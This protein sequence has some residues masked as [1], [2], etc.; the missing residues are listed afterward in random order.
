MK[1]IIVVVILTIM[2]VISMYYL[3]RGEESVQL[4]KQ[5]CPMYVINMDSS[6]ERYE[7]FVES[8]NNSQFKNYKIDR[9]S[10]I[11]GK[12][13][14]PTDW[15]SPHGLQEF[16]EV[17]NNGYRTKHHQLTRGGI[18]CFL[19]H[20]FLAQQLL[21][22]P[23][24]DYYLIFED[25]AKFDNQSYS[26]ILKAFEHAPDDWDYLMFRTIMISGNEENEYFNKLG[27][28]WLMIC[29]MMNKQGARKLVDEVQ[30]HMIDGQ[31]DAYLSRMSLQDKINIYGVKT[32]CISCSWA[33]DSSIQ[34]DIVTEGVDEFDYNGVDLNPQN[35]Y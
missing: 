29:Y 10:A 15:L 8:C 14:E 17:Q 26:N 22:D 12:T 1:T 2:I 9:F 25:D 4:E 6:K 16:E 19:S 20:Y 30:K 3:Y 13:V 33:T 23:D 31:I 18:G 32:D 34:N 27:S 21:E 35:I 11:D 28:F 5:L 7:L 24:N